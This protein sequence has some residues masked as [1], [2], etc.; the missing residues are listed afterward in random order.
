MGKGYSITSEVSLGQ[1]LLAGYERHTQRGPSSPGLP[2]IKI[3][4]ITNDTSATFASLSYTARST[5]IRRVAMGLIVGTGVNAA[6]PLM[7]QSLHPTKLASI[8]SL[9]G[10]SNDNQI[11]MVNT[12]W[13]IRGTAA[14]LMKHKLITEWDLELDEGCEAP[15]YM[16]FEY[17]TGGRYLGELVRI[18]AR[19]YLVTEKG[20]DIRDLP[21]ALTL[22]NGLDTSTL[23]SIYG[24]DV[25]A[26]EALLQLTRALPPPKQNAWI[27]TFE[28]MHDLRLIA[29]AVQLRSSQMVAAGVVAGLALS[30]ELVLDD[31]DNP[32]YAGIH[33]ESKCCELI[34]AFTGGVIS[35]YPSYLDDCQKTINALVLSL[36]ASGVKQRVVLEEVLNGGVTGAGV[37]AGTLWNP[38]A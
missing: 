35:K 9:A 1:L 23:S 14:P 20:Y 18:I 7:R 30:G 25:S 31:V 22:R 37:L 10:D 19:R 13:G 38:P 33:R 26:D 34:V 11:I 12:E 27:W 24:S 15:G 6:I 36:S 5:A 29:Q 32:R 28:W 8:P 21:L 2:S 16:P 4:A 3:A 17:M